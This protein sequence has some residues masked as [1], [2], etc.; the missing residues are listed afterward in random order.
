MSGGG[1]GGTTLPWPPAQATAG[2]RRALPPGPSR[3]PPGRPP[4]ASCLLGPLWPRRPWPLPRSCPRAAL[5]PLASHHGS[6]FRAPL[7]SSSGTLCRGRAL[8]SPERRLHRPPPASLRPASVHGPG[9]LLPALPPFP[10]FKTDPR[11]LL[12]ACRLPHLSGSGDP[13]PLPSS[14]CPLSADLKP[15]RGGGSPR[16]T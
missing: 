13:G 4:A 1:A 16:E 12:P 8:P 7:A 10:V 11:L 15:R 14:R 6:A 5:P 2:L 9:F 3:A